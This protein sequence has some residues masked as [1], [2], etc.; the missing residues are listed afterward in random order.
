MNSMSA[1]MRTENDSTNVYMKGSILLTIPESEYANSLQEKVQI[2]V[3]PID[4]TSCN[5]LRGY[6]SS[7]F[8]KR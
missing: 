7:R 3:S 2:R 1:S 4:W 6:R 5:I 8:S